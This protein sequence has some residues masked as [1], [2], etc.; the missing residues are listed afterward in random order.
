M[1]DGANFTVS[2]RARKV[3]GQMPAP[4]TIDQLVDSIRDKSGIEAPGADLLL[5]NSY[6]ALIDGVS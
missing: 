6:A 3:Y 2:D 1:Y 4:G 5:A